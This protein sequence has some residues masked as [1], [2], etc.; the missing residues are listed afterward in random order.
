MRSSGGAPSNEY[1]YQV[2]FKLAKNKKYV[3]YGV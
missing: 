1:S 2:W 3:G